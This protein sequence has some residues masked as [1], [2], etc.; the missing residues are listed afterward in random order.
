[1]STEFESYTQ[2]SLNVLKF[3][4]DPWPTINKK[5]AL[6]HEVLDSHGLALNSVLFVGFSPWCFSKKIK[7]V[8]ITALSKDAEE[9]LTKHGV[10]YTH[11]PF[12]KI[13]S[14]TDTF[15]C[16]VAIDEYF[17]F[18]VDEQ[19]QI[20]TITLLSD[21]TNKILITTLR[22]YKNIDFKDKEFNS[23]EPVRCCNDVTCNSAKIIT[24]YHNYNF[25]PTD[26]YSWKSMVYELHDEKMLFHGSFI[27]RAM[28]FKQLA[29]FTSDVGAKAFS[30]YKPS[31]YKSVIRRN[32]EHIIS[33]IF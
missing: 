27:R 26:R 15:D 25:N 16:V 1:M 32:Y 12:N 11:I 13:I 19:Q 8:Y 20:N 21:C 33:I 18:A 6:F 10:S 3:L 30:A 22:D 4:D 24:E 14:G 9:F 2:A 28:F 17:T 31:L 7:N 23:P 29:K 5:V